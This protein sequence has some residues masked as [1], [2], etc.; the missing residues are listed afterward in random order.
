VN[1]TLVA[2]AISE[3]FSDTSVYTTQLQCM[4]TTSQW[5]SSCS[6]P[7]TAV[8]LTALG[9]GV[10]LSSVG[11]PAD[12]MNNRWRYNY[13]VAH[14]AKTIVSEMVWKAVDE[15]AKL[16]NL[17]Q[18]KPSYDPVFDDCT[19]FGSGHIAGPSPLTLAWAPSKDV[20]G[21][22]GFGWVMSCVWPAF[23]SA[24][25]TA[26]GVF[27]EQKVEM[28]NTRFYGAEAPDGFSVVPK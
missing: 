17:R 4:L 27:L 19:E 11:A 9:H 14:G 26:Q 20:W 6:Y 7:Y 1:L 18:C 25:S 2:L 24:T 12:P 8:Y 5:V 3:S 22:P 28:F 23:P 13:T 15:N 21:A 10:N 16:M